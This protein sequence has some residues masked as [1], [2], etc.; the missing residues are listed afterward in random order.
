MPSPAGHHSW[1]RQSPPPQRSPRLGWD[2]RG[3]RPPA[4]PARPARVAAGARADG[5][6][7][8]LWVRHPAAPRLAGPGRRAAIRRRQGRTSP[9]ARHRGRRPPQG[10][11][12]FLSGRCTAKRLLR[13]PGP[14]P[15]SPSI[16]WQ[17]ASPA[18]ASGIPASRAR[19]SNRAAARAASPACS[20]APARA[21]ATVPSP[22]TM[23]CARSSH[24]SASA[25]WPAADAARLRRQESST[26][27]CHI[28]ERVRLRR[29]LRPRLGIGQNSGRAPR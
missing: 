27:P 7:P 16:R 1:S 22:G 13:P 25:G 28:S 26:S 2:C 23:R 10:R 5:S 17:A 9:P 20:N 12:R 14:S 4:P 24:C 3:S 6:R 21:A 15:V 18:H 11:A 29:A 19:G 8:V